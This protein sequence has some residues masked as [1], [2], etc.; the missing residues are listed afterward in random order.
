MQKETQ[1][2]DLGNQE[3]T[4]SPESLDQSRI[5]LLNFGARTISL[6]SDKSEQQL[7]MFQKHTFLVKVWGWGGSV[8]TFQT[9]TMSLPSI[10][11]GIVSYGQCDLFLEG[12]KFH[13]EGPTLMTYVP[14]QGFLILSFGAGDKVVARTLQG[15]APPTS[16]SGSVCPHYCPG[17]CHPW[18]SQE[19]HI[20]ASPPCST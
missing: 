2:L 9:N 12:P 6:A 4:L 14:H 5:S 7:S 3:E 10:D 17:F 13:H 18:D 11:S 19:H 1:F 16:Q 15:E 20:S 8:G